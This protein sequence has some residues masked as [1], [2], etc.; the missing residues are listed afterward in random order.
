MFKHHKS[1]V[2]SMNDKWLTLKLGKEAYLPLIED[3]NFDVFEN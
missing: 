3:K 2:V 1:R